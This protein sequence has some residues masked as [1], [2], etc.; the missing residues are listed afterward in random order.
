[1]FNASRFA[2]EQNNAEW[3]K[4]F[5][6]ISG[7]LAKVPLAQWQFFVRFLL[8]ICLSFSLANLFW[9]LL[10]APVVPEAVVSIAMGGNASDTSLVNPENSVVDI[11][12][13]K[14]L[15]LFGSAIAIEQ[16]SSPVVELPATETQ[17]KLVL[18]G[19]VT[20]NNNTLARAVISSGNNQDVYAIGAEL[21]VGSGVSLFDVMLDRVII[22]NN[23]QLESLF[24]YQNDVRTTAIA[25]VNS[26]PLSPQ[27]AQWLADHAEP[28]GEPPQTEAAQAEEIRSQQAQYKTDLVVNPVAVKGPLTPEMAEWLKDHPESDPNAQESSAQ[29]N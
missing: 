1:M 4:Y 18:L 8:V 24:L 21:P 10:P 5:I 20:S 17:L 23:G 22:N 11:N 16:N 19:V 13:L 28:E 27:M 14:S 15:R 7:S 6:A 12:R 26:A 25:A 29:E 2:V 3:Q 9:L